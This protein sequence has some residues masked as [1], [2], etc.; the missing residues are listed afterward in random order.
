MYDHIAITSIIIKSSAG[1]KADVI[2]LHSRK[3][4]IE[5]IDIKANVTP[6]INHILVLLRVLL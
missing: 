4:V 3:F 6:I 1:S 5:T 2:S